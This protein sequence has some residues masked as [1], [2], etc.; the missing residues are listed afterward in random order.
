MGP[1]GIVLR[2]DSG[3]LAESSRSIRPTIGVRRLASR[4]DNAGAPAW[5][6]TSMWRLDPSGVDTGARE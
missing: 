6:P 5:H 4:Y 1:G 2:L 3:R